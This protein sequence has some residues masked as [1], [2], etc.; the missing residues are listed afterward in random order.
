MR[1]TALVLLVA[2]LT[3]CGKGAGEV[4]EPPQQPPV[5]ATAADLAAV[6]GK[7]AIVRVEQAGAAPMGPEA[8]RESEVEIGEQELRIG[9]GALGSFHGVFDLDA[10]RSPKHLD[11]AETNSDGKPQSRF[12]P[13]KTGDVVAAIYKLEG[14]TLVVAAAPRAGEPRPTEFRPSPPAPGRTAGVVVVYLNRK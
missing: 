9:L 10:K 2:A 1:S 13:G 7:W 8:F 12:L 3:G 5:S 14:D 4:P 6:Q 11:L